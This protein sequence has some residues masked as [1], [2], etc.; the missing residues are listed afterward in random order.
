MIASTEM[1]RH[2]NRAYV[3]AGLRELGPSA[4]TTLAEWSGLSSASVS[5]ITAELER[6]GVLSRLDHIAGSGRGRPRVLLGP[7]ATFAYVAAIRITTE[8]VEYSLIDYAGTLVDRFHE[9]RP[10]DEKSRSD[11]IR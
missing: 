1:L 6:E 3:L 8:I 5:A 9:A 11:L 4:H 2:Q 7:N 10:A